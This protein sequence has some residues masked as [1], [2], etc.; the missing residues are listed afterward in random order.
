MESHGSSL[1]SRV[2]LRSTEQFLPRPLPASSR[3]NLERRHVF[4]TNHGEAPAVES[5][6]DPCAET[7]GRGY[8]R[9][10][11]GTEGK[12]VVCGDQFRDADPVS[13][14]NRFREQ[15]AGC[16]ISEEADL[17]GPSE[18]RLEEVSDLRHD[19]LGHDEGTFVR[20]QERQADLVIAIV[21]V[22]VCVE[23]PGIDDQRDRRASRRRISSMRRAVSRRPLRPA[24]AAIRR[25]RPPPPR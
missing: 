23:R 25:R 4:R 7:F 1:T 24:F 6:N 22:D 13:R 18:P 3:K 10:I 9:R 19:E 14:E 12:V 16:Q 11:H 17:R 5:G 21:L 8:H 2:A 20:L 15:V